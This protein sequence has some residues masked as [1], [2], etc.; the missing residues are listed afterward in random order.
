MSDRWEERW[1]VAA[2]AGSRWG[3]ALTGEVVGV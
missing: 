1:G 3:V 2:L